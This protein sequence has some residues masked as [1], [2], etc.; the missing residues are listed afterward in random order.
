[1][2]PSFLAWVLVG[3]IVGSTVTADILQTIEMKRHGEVS[4][5]RPGRLARMFA[6]LLGRPF[7]VM[8]VLFMA[9]SFF[10]F[11]KLLTVADLSFAV[12]A[13]AVSFVVETILARLL[14][15]EKVELKRWAGV[16]LI[17]CGVLLLAAQ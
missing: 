9:L 11:M 7:L 4:D 16:G 13:T 14:L 6:K 17:A 3:V 12:P 1:M 10:A 5:F 2:T 8:T 15:K